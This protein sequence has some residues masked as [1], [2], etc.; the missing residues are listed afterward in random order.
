MMTKVWSAGGDPP[1]WHTGGGGKT[2]KE[3][4]WREGR[5]AERSERQAAGGHSVSALRGYSRQKAG[6]TGD[7]EKQPEKE[8]TGSVLRVSLIDYMFSVFGF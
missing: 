3:G 6:G 4:Q 1:A 7:L 2:K 8:K 5:I